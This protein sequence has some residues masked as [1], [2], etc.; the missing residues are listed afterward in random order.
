MIVLPSLFYSSI[1]NICT[2]FTL[3]SSSIIQNMIASPHTLISQYYKNMIALPSLL[4]SLSIIKN[5]IAQ[6]SHSHFKDPNFMQKH[7][8]T[9]ICQRLC[10]K[11]CT[12]F[13]L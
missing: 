8:F 7:F 3:Q 9:K 6:P 12:T 13:P 5:R 2:T 1:L 11:E 10:A 4:L